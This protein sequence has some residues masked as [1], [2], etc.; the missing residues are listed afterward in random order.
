[1]DTLTSMLAEFA[2]LIDLKRNVNDGKVILRANER[3]ED[4][5]ATLPAP[6]RIKR[7]VVH[8]S[9]DSFLRYLTEWTREDLRVFIGETE[10]VALI[11][12][13]V[14]DEPK[15]EEHRAI[16]PLSPTHAF[17]TWSAAVTPDG[18]KSID[19][20]TLALLFDRR[21]G[22]VLN[23]AAATMMEIA[24]TLEAKPKVA[25]KSAVRLDNGDRQFLFEETTDARAGTK[26]D[27]IIP[28]AFKVLIPLYE[29]C[30]AVTL[31]VK[32]RYRLNEGK[33]MFTLE[34]ADLEEAKKETARHMAEVLHDTTGEQPYH[35]TATR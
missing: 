33:I 27:I 9:F 5:E 23:P 13:Q 10:I 30:D 28:Q 34:W 25:W 19:Q 20:G 14:P 18:S 11:D 16:F 3:L 35:G 21:A 15:W 1:M 24:T 4:V 29:G 22:D 31:D 17:K 6:L 2:A 26:G 7:R 12:A 8:S 32:L